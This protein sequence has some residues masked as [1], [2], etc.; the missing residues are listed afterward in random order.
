M[1]RPLRKFDEMNKLQK[2][3]VL[4]RDDDN[5][6]RSIL[7]N[8]QRTCWVCG[9]KAKLKYVFKILIIFHNLIFSQ[10]TKYYFYNANLETELLAYESKWLSFFMILKN[11]E[12]ENSK[13]LRQR[14]QI[15]SDCLKRFKC[16]VSINFHTE[17]YLNRSLRNIYLI[18]ESLFNLV[19]IVIIISSRQ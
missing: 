13:T 7:K 4:L 2:E 8:I 14:L 12:S 9:S 3:L 1:Y 11:K 17:M 5:V 10:Y 18:K 15:C 16:H 6:P 19:V